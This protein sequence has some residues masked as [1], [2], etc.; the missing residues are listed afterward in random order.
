MSDD[1]ISGTRN[2]RSDDHRI[3]R[4]ETRVD[5]M[6]RLHE[7]RFAS[8]IRML[9]SNSENLKAIY[10]ILWSGAVSTIA[11]L[12]AGFGSLF[13]AYINLKR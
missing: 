3:V 6:E 11:I 1:V 8:V 5:G 9:D 13:M 2:R 7:E 4:L 12:I 10:K